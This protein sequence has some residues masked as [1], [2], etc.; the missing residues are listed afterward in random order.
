MTTE[1]GKQL[2]KEL[3]WKK[4]L[5]E[6]GVKNI[7]KRVRI[8]GLKTREIDG[9]TVAV[10]RYKDSDSA[11]RTTGN[12][13]AGKTRGKTHHYV[14]IDGQEIGGARSY[15]EA[16]ANAA[17]DVAR[18]AKDSAKPANEDASDNEDK[19]PATKK[20]DAGDGGVVDGM[21]KYASLGA[22]LAANARQR[23]PQRAERGRRNANAGMKS[24]GAGTPAV[25]VVTR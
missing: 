5:G 1:Y 4:Q 7:P 19:K 14:Y 25:K 8:T 23:M 6:L 15:K 16:F 22:K 17:E 20:D 13:S 18:I 9:H 2:E 10:L 3:A 21:T 24:G 11:I 12:L